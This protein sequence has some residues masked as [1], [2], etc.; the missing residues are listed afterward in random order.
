LDGTLVDSKITILKSTLETLKTLNIEATLQEDK[1]FKMIGMHFIDIFNEFK[2]EVPDFNKFISVYKSF[3]FNF[4]DDSVSYPRAADVL[5]HLNEKGI[6]TSL[7]TTKAQDQADKIINHFGFRENLS[8]VMGRRN[9]IAHKPSAK[10]LLII[11]D[12]LGIKPAE[13]LMVGDTELDINCG[14]NAGA[15]SC[16]VTYG[17]RSEEYLKEYNPDFLIDDI[18]ELKDSVS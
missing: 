2:I 15:L 17:Y 3:Y 14:K 4:I 12:G 16:G 6:K 5:K 10:P 8:Y 7:L 9:G 1:F 13:T 18:I 11:C